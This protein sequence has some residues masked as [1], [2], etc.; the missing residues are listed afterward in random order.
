[1]GVAAT[2]P[3]A[4]AGG[5][6]TTHVDGEAAM[7]GQRRAA[8]LEIR[9]RALRDRKLGTEGWLKGNVGQVQRQHRRGGG[10]SGSQ[11]CPR[12]ADRA[13][14]VGMTMVLV[15]QPAFVVSDRRQQGTGGGLAAAEALEVNVAK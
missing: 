1:M 4:V 13:E 15:R 6:R 3:V 14:I 7:S 5:S 12:H 9:A 2:T 8:R 11:R 10:K